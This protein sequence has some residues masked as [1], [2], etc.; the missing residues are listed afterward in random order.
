MTIDFIFQNL[1]IQLL[2]FIYGA[3]VLFRFQVEKY[4]TIK[5][6]LLL[7]VKTQYSCWQ[8][9][10]PKQTLILDKFSYRPNSNIHS[11]KVFLS[12]FLEKSYRPFK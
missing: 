2:K 4:K 1:A 5:I 7:I 8:P 11:Q 6:K 10:I 9:L 3:N 12:L